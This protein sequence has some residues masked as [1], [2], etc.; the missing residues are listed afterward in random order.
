M[1]LRALVALG[2]LLGGCRFDGIQ[3]QGVPDTQIALSPSHI[4]EAVNGLVRIWPRDLSRVDDYDLDLFTGCSC[5]PPSCVY[6]LQAPFD[7]RVRYDSAAGRWYFLGVS[8]YPSHRWCLGVSPGSD[9]RLGPYTYAEI[10]APTGIVADGADIGFSDD[11]ILLTTDDYGSPLVVINKPA[12]LAGQLYYSFITASHND[13]ALRPFANL[14]GE[15]AA[16]AAG[17]RSGDYDHVTSWKVTGNVPLGLAKISS[18]NSVSPPLRG[19]IQPP[20]PGTSVRL[21]VRGYGGIQSGGAL[22][23]DGSWWI[24]SHG[25]CTPSGDVERMCV[26]L[27]EFR[28]DVFPGS[29][30]LLVRQQVTIKTPGWYWFYPAFSID[31]SGNVVAVMNGISASTYASI[32]AA[33]R[34]ATDPLGSYRG[35]FLLRAGLSPYDQGGALASDGSAIRY[36]DYS[37]A[38]IDPTDPAH[39]WL[40]AEYPVTRDTYGT[41]I[42]QAGANCDPVRACCGC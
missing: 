30:V 19:A 8:Q 38:A 16:F 5:A 33:G 13:L 27:V 25:R 41:W 20:Q 32:Y 12:L 42:S 37:G 1:R 36:G 18:V 7:P 14:S 40:A 17:A 34:L 24:A 9:P 31:S 2:V 23:R 21:D 28:D 6:Y 39:V 15:A 4:V 22:Y 3:G 11:K 26:N 10:P 29:F 35:P